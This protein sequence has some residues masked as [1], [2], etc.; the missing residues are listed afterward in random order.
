MH[1]C[2]KS[3]LITKIERAVSVYVCVCVC[4]CVYVYVYVCMCVCVCV[5]QPLSGEQKIE[6]E[7]FKEIKRE[8]FLERER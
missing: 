5:D 6:I 7:N 4:V 8:C 3:N 1:T 2:V